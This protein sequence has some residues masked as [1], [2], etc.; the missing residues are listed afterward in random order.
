[1]PRDRLDALLEQLGTA[2]DEDEGR[3]EA[4]ERARLEAL[5]ETQPGVTP[6]VAD[7]TDERG[8]AAIE[9]AIERVGGVDVCINN[10]GVSGAADPLTENLDHFRQVVDVNLVALFAVTQI[11]ARHMVSAGRGS[12]I[13]IASFVGLVSSAPIDQPGYCAAKGG[14]IAMTRELAVSW[15]R[16]GVRVNAIAPGFFPSEMTDHMWDDDRTVAFIERNCPMHRRGEIDELHPELLGQRLGDLLLR[17]EFE[18]DEGFARAFARLLGVLGGLVRLG[19]VDHAVAHEDLTQ[20][21]A[22]SCHAARV[23]FSTPALGSVLAHPAPARGL[24]RGVR[25]RSGGQR[26]RPTPG[27]G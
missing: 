18:L 17:R 6:V 20:L 23:T 22:R 13:N 16:T 7:I 5:A 3:L 21:L 8:I 26:P 1:M 27:V 25:R 10:A 12:I 24:P 19:G 14:V 15:G 2:L 9:A 11:A 4:D